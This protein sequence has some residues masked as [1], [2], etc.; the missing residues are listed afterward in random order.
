[1]AKQTDN[2]FGEF[3]RRERESLGISL[4][5]MAKQ[6]GVTAAYLSMVELGNVN[7]PVEAKVRKIAA[8]INCDADALLA[9]SGKIAHDVLDVVRRNPVEMAALIRAVDGMDVRAIVSMAGDAVVKK[10]WG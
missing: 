1:M 3:I 7:P 2:T 6:I 9:R 10:K 8:A 4:R 5:K